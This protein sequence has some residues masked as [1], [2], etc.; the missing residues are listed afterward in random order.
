[1]CVWQQIVSAFQSVV[2][3][4]QTKQAEERV[5]EILPFLTGLTRDSVNGINGGFHKFFFSAHLP[6]RECLTLTNEHRVHSV[7]LDFS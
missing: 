5:L 2:I 7:H 1:M 4:P 6:Y 3:I